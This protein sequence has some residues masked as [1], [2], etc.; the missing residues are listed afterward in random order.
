VKLIPT[1]AD[2]GREQAPMSHILRL[3]DT[4]LYNA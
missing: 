2:Q 4:G 3:A 1:T